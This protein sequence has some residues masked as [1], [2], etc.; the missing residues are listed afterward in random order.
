MPKG[1]THDVFT[2]ALLPIIMIATYILFGFYFTIILSL[3]YLFSGFM[4]NGDLDIKS[5]PTNRWGPLKFIWYPYRKL[6][7]HR[8]F[9]SHG[10]FVGTLIRVLWVIWIPIVILILCKISIL[11]LLTDYFIEIVFTL[12]GL[13][14]GSMSHTLLDIIS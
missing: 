8:S 3:G 2:L 9:W 4:F 12:I 5:R 14:C 6:F 1:E 7:K 10:L 11:P 13:E